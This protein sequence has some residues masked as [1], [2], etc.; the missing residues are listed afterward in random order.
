MS[1]PTAKTMAT[2][3]SQILTTQA[4]GVA[5]TVQADYYMEQD[6]LSTRHDITVQF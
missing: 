6:K 3:Q 2:P 5:V 1:M 4:E